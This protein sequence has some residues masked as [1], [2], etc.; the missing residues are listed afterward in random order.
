MEL[1]D[2][3]IEKVLAGKSPVSKGAEAN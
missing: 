2:S 1:K 3:M